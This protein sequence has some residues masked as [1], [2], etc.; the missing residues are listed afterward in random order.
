MNSHFLY[1]PSELLKAIKDFPKGTGIL[2]FRD[3]PNIL[4]QHVVGKKTLD[5]GCGA[6]RSSRILNALGYDVCGVDIASTM[7]NSARLLTSEIQ[8]KVV[9]RPLNRLL[10]E[11]YD[12]IFLSF[13]LMEMTKAADIVVTLQQLKKQL[14]P[15]GRVVVI[16]ASNE[17][18]LHEWLSMKPMTKNI[19]SGLPAEILLKDYNTTVTDIVWSESDCFEFFAGSGFSL[20]EKYYP[21]GQDRDDRP[22]LI[23]TEIA[24]FVIWVLA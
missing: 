13:V 19:N 12:L 8:F 20:I 14:N 15:N 23:E 2:A 17:M 22:W 11:T 10:T 18:Y 5:F 6:G 9:D 1:D 21:L 3:I 16:T 4:N 24:P 7:I